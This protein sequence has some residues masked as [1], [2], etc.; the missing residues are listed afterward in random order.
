MTE[1]RDQIADAIA[2][3]R[4]SAEPHELTIPATYL[5]D[6]ETDA[7]MDAV[8]PLV[9]QLRALNQRI[10]RPRPLPRPVPAGQHRPRY[11]RPNGVH[12]MA[13][14]ATKAVYR[15]IWH[16]DYDVDVTLKGRTAAH[17]LADEMA[18]ALSAAGL[19]AGPPA[20]HV[21]QDIEWNPCEDVWRPGFIA[22]LDLAVIVLHENDQY[23]TV[24]TQYIRPR[25]AAP[26]VAPNVAAES[27]EEPVGH[28]ADGVALIA[29]ERQRQIAKGW[30]AEHDDRHPGDQLVQAAMF[31][32]DESAS[33]TDWPWDTLPTRGTRIR[34]LERAGA[35][36]AAEI[37]RLHRAAGRP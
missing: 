21:G 33:A 18:T 14:A 37:D 3:A 22:D 2:K 32:A 17:Q 8:A 19:L 15:A 11:R 9:E 5:L 1:L 26:D 16:S 28:G 23:L 24:G 30:T 35:L 34:D 4:F 10:A 27:R 12:L 20:W 36:I 25:I 31:Y 7:V 6:R 29:L 13:G